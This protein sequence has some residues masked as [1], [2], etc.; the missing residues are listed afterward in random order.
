MV[1][2]AVRLLGA[3]GPDGVA[4]A[5]RLHHGPAGGR[6]AAARDGVAASPVV[7]LLPDLAPLRDGVVTSRTTGTLK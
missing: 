2:G 1:L 6:R 5:P 4:T 7:A 3:H